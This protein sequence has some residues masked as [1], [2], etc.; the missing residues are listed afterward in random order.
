M[1]QPNDL[2]ACEPFVG[3]T[4]PVGGAGDAGAGLRSNASMG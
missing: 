2:R 3:E 4:V 1:P